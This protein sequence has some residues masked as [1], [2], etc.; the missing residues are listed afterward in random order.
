[1]ANDKESIIERTKCL[2]MMYELKSSFKNMQHT[3]Y[4]M[5]GRLSFSEA[6]EYLGV[7]LLEMNALIRDKVIPYEKV[8]LR[9]YVFRTEDLDEYLELTN[10]GKEAERHG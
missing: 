1:M 8:S 7:G 10:E 9:R 4:S 3:L 2:G 5:K 6:R